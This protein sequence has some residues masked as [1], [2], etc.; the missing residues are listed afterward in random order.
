MDP[1]KER[2]VE[3]AEPASFE[4]AQSE[5]PISSNLASMLLQLKGAPKSEEENKGPCALSFEPNEEV[6]NVSNKVIFSS[7][8]YCFNYF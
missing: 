4:P 5:T 8:I 2:T 6:K 7:L 3:S 1:N